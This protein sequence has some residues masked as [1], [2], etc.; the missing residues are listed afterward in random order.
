MNGRTAGS[1]LRASRA[2]LLVCAVVLLCGLALKTTD[3]FDRDGFPGANY[4]DIKALW[5]FRP[6][7]R[8]VMRT[9]DSV[10]GDQLR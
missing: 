8:P 4:S 10:G 2:P 1:V 9:P 7:G 3:V 5:P 6:I